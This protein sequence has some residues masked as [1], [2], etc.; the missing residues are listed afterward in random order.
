M[1]QQRSIP[2]R[3]WRRAGTL[4]QPLGWVPVG[5]LGIQL[6]YRISLQVD[7]VG[8]VHD[9]VTD[10]IG[11]GGSASRSCCAT[12]LRMAPAHGSNSCANSSAVRPDRTNSTSCWRNSGA[13][14]RCVL[15]IVASSFRVTLNV[16][17]KAGQLQM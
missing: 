17:T 15:G 8:A 12:Q 9:A 1:R 5:T 16:S 10:R 14:G 6:A 4:A 3:S 2:P 11:D 13:Y 7:A